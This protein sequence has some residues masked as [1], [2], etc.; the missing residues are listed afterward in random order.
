MQNLN[1]PSPPPHTGH[2]IVYAHF[3]IQVHTVCPARYI[4]TEKANNKKKYKTRLSF[5]QTS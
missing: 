2:H 5:N 1:I 3:V 4:Y